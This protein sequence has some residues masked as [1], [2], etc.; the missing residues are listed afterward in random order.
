[1][2]LILGLSL[3]LLG[4][5][6]CTEAS[7]QPA[8]EAFAEPAPLVAMNLAAHPDDEDGAT[9]NYYRHA[10]DA[11]VYSVIFTRGEGGQN[12]IGPELYHALGAIRSK[13]TE[14]AARALGTQVHFLNF[15]DFGYSKIAD[16][17]FEEWGGRDFV[18]ARLVYLIRKLKP[19]VLFT[20]HDTVTT[21][22]RRQHGQHQAVGIAGYDAFAL[23]ADA[24]YHP[25]QLEEEGVD[26]WQPKRLYLR[27]FFRSDDDPYDMAVPVGDVDE[28]AS[29]SYASNAADALAHHA[30]QGMDMFARRL[31]RLTHNYFTVLRTVTEAPP[32]EDDLAAAL[33]PNTEAQ[34]DVPYLID[35]GR[36]AP[37]SEDVY[38]LS[39]SIAVPGQSVRLRWDSDKLPEKRLR[40]EFRGAIDT[41]L[42]LADST[43]G[44]ATLDVT[45]SAIPTLPKKVNQY[46]R[47][48]NHP[49]VVYAAYRAGTEE[50]LAA[51]YLPL[52]V[53][54]PLYVEAAATEIRLRPGA[55]R[56]P[57]QARVFDPAAE[58]VSVNVAVSRDADRTV[59]FQQQVPVSVD[60]TGLAIDT[61]NVAMPE[62]LPAGTYTITLTGLA[63]PATH[64][65][66]PA[67]TRT[68]GRVF[69]VAVAE[70]LKVGVV[71]SY[72]NTLQQALQELEVDYVMLDSLALA[73]A[74][75]D[76]LHTI[77]LD[78]RSYL[79]RHDL[80][81]YN[82]KLLDWVRE[83]GHLI[84]N[85]QKTFEWNEQYADPFDANLKNPGT[86]AP[87]P[88][89]LGRD[90]VTR[91]D[92]VVTVKH[93]DHPFMNQPNVITPA[94]WDGWVQERGL[95]FPRTWDEAYDELF[96]MNDPGEAPLCGSTLQA[97][98]GQ[99]TY[100]Y[101][102]L[103]WYR[104][105]KVYHPGAYA[106]FANMISLPL[107]DNRV[108]SSSP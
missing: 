98:Y 68:T 11:V 19:D 13:E 26:L 39:D 87:Y 45:T 58:Q 38:S 52:E 8:P 22:P 29:Q 82:D 63:K 43:P 41:T 40:W 78:I 35:A 81:T 10:K 17:A 4:V 77:V 28:G 86:F 30:S 103:V 23:A 64:E 27:H 74:A 91:E 67:R 85:Y 55:N 49:P 50:L 33:P 54:P 95:Y 1:M 57:M 69:H 3:L 94:A 53:A 14:G 79:I 24:S 44:V 15:Y 76:G 6:A 106:M 2:R 104:Q 37:L 21:G 25:E 75:F 105:L 32:V 89:V 80:R 62:T 46:N 18:T 56:L 65:P 72:D 90:R 34:P 101:S 96:C 71:D 100:L 16:E 51:G 84:V 12:E 42:Y 92:A 48:T 88:L 73:E 83:G 59:V 20:N 9:M 36:L 31:R 66:L 99:G 47:F 107:V 102:A 93:T 7:T 70:G 108:S 5:A 61:V 97:T 60:D